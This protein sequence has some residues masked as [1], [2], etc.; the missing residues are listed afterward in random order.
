MKTKNPHLYYLLLL[1]LGMLFI[2][3][4]GVLGRYIALPPP[5]SIWFRSLIA[6]ILLI[7]YSIYKKFTF[8][9][10]WKKH[11]AAVWWSGFFMAL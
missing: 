2:S 1:N 7:L 5:V 3:T 10:N 6:I 8:Q 11:G 9:I 4:S